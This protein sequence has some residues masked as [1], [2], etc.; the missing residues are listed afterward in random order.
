MDELDVNILIQTFN[1]KL[2]QL[3]TELVVKEATIKQLDSK[4]K[5]LSAAAYPAKIEKVKNDNKKQSEDFE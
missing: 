2:A 5:I 3:T 1:E 4:I